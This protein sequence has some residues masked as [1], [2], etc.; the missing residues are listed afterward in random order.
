MS[1]KVFFQF[2]FVG[3]KI[4]AFGKDNSKIQYYIVCELNGLK[5]FDKS[6]DYLVISISI[7]L[8]FVFRR[9]LEALIFGTLVTQI[10]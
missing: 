8:V 9:V 10:L 3:F 1:V 5:L 7:V 6:H 4:K 2:Y